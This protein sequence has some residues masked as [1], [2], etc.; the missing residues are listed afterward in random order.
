MK[1]KAIEVNNLFS[2]DNFKIE[3]NKWNI[4]VIVGPNNAGKTN[5]FRVLGFLK[6]VINDKIK[7]EDVPNYLHDRNIRYA[8]IVVDIEFD[9]LEKD[10]LKNYFECFL[11]S[12]HPE[13]KK[14]CDELGFNIE[15]KLVELFSKGKF[16]WEFRGEP[17]GRVTPYYKIPIKM[18][19]DEKLKEVLK[20]LSIFDPEV[21]KSNK[22]ELYKFCSFIFDISD[23][24]EEDIKKFLEDYGYYFTDLIYIIHYL[25]N[26][27]KIL[28]N[29]DIYFNTDEKNRILLYNSQNEPIFEVKDLKS[30]DTHIGGIYNFLKKYS[31]KA[32]DIIFLTLLLAWLASL[33]NDD[34]YYGKILDLCKNNP[35][36]NILSEKAKNL[37]EY[38]YK[39]FNVNQNLLF[40]HFIQKLFDKAIIKFEEVRGSP[41]S[42]IKY[43]KVPIDL[44][45]KSISS[46]IIYDIPRTGE[47]LK[48]EF[49]SKYKI[50][51]YG[52]DSND[53]YGNGEDLA[54]YLFYL[55]NAH[56]ID[57]RSKYK[58][59]RKSFKEIFKTEKID[60]DVVNHNGYPEIYIIFEKDNGDIDY[61]L[62]INRVG[63]GIFEVLNI[64]A[65]VIGN[66][67][68]VILLD[69]PALHLHPVYQK[70]LLK[71]FEDLGKDKDNQNRKKSNQIIIVTHSPYFV[72]A[73]F[74]NN[75][76]RFYKENE[77]TKWINVGEIIKQQYKKDIT[78]KFEENDIKKRILF[79]NG[80]LLVEGDCEYYT[81]PILLEK[82]GY[83]IEDYNIEI[84]NV[85]GK[86]GFKEYIALLNELK[87]PFGIVCDGD[88]AFNIYKH[89]RINEEKAEKI[90]KKLNDILDSEGL[91]EE[92]IKSEINEIIKKYNTDYTLKNENDYSTLINAFKDVFNNE[93]YPFWLKPNEYQEILKNITENMEK[94]RNDLKKKGM[95]RLE[96]SKDIENYCIE[97]LY[98]NLNE[99]FKKLN[100]FAC[101]E[102]DWHMFLGSN[103]KNIENCIK[104]TYEFNDEEKL[105]EL[106]Q[107]IQNFI[108]KCIS[109]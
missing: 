18:L 96:S 75:T 31:L 73:E 11:K 98:N 108:N 48:K 70:K 93:K 42:F 76:F 3:F 85:R 94:L 16:I 86:G 66:K 29:D 43:I 59:F 56:E 61:Q 74:L 35:L 36:D 9:D 65:V 90:I 33:K 78:K 92:T 83:S 100:V 80:V 106:K 46:S 51:E 10:M 41:D 27:L 44:W 26:L 38:T 13:F 77:A 68:K 79:A 47:R 2:Y 57:I 17:S 84:I 71:V 7:A 55:K 60:F 67:N 101:K 6:D 72:S 58:E 40:R 30:W 82:I 37:F 105:N 97:P 8:K 4:A 104:K 69:E 89:N 28:I 22:E 39:Q 49:E 24:S 103:N 95:D 45:I 21:L 87:I 102:Y 81:L 88:T 52:F 5:L 20:K 23:A 14:I 50:P 91:T 25:L 53:Y 63:S 109:P 15:E 19:K 32:K 12:N 62:P 34:L 107:F 54:K 99:N 1:I 64:L